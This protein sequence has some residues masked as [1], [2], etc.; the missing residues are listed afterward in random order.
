MLLIFCVLTC[1]TTVVVLLLTRSKPHEK[2]IQQR[3][4]S[5]VALQES[6]TEHDE[7][8]DLGLKKQT[9]GGL[10][11]RITQR[12]RDYAAAQ[13]L[14][15]KLL[16]AGWDISV[17]KFLVITATSAIGAA[18][19]AHLFVDQLPIVGIALI[20]GG[21]ANF[22]L[23]RFKR[24]RRLKKFNEALPDSIDLMSRALKA[25]HAMSSA[26]EVVA[27]QSPEPLRSEFSRCAQQQRFGIPFRESM[28]EMSD[29]V[30]SQ[31][32]YF[33]ITAILVQKETGGDLTEILDR[34][35][36][37]IRE[38]VRIHGEIKTH[39]AQGRLTGWILSAL[40]V[41]LLGVISIISPQYTHVLFHDP[42]GQKLLY[43]AAGLIS[44]GS[45]VI[46][47]I[48]DIKV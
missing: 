14:E 3:L 31:D 32:M 23:L 5:L 48:V 25:G 8:D 29:R 44:M 24:N 20:A 7:E 36:E 33:V 37:V 17:G 40:P 39:T 15:K 13:R 6:A 26:I 1:V 18:L 45:F 27:E 4:D 2:R 12:V 42:L 38:R 43:T 10:S 9:A 19:I 46:N 47:R 28:L 11:G 41:V 30:P 34:T 35:T 22:G 21:A 16:H